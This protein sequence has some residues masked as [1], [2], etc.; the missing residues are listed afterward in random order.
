MAL[1]ATVYCNLRAVDFPTVT[2]LDKIDVSIVQP[3][4]SVVPE[5]TVGVVNCSRHKLELTRQKYIEAIHV[6]L[7]IESV[8]RHLSV[9]A[10][11]TFKYCSLRFRRG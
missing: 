10:E 3:M 5:V 2:P 8:Q 1:A 4:F 6:S 9:V 11:S 7:L